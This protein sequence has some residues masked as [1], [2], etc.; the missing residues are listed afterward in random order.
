[1]TD[2]SWIDECAALINN[3]KS[4]KQFIE[5]MNWFVDNHNEWY[6]DKKGNWSRGRYCD[7]DESNN[8]TH[9]LTVICILKP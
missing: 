7:S 8:K 2:K 3:Q 9:T 1:M 5:D 6:T 4:T